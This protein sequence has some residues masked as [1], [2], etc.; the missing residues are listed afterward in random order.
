MIIQYKN[1]LAFFVVICVLIGWPCNPAASSR[2]VVIG[3]PLPLTGDLKE[4]GRIMKNSFELARQTINQA[5]G[6]N[7]NPVELRFADT[8][9]NVSQADKVVKDLVAAGSVMMVGGYAS[10]PT[11]RMA[12]RAQQ[13]NLPF[14]ISTA[15]ADKITRRGWKN[16]YRLNPP[17][18][19]YTKGLEDF[20]VKNLKPRSM[21]IVYENSM[22]GTTG[23]MRM[24]EFCQDRAI[25]IRA[26][27]TYDRTTARPAYLHSLLAPLTAEPPDVIYMIAYLEDAVMLVQQ[28]R[29]LK[30][31]A[32]L[33]GGAGGFALEEFARRAGNAANHLLTASLWSQNV[34]Y[35][36]A[37]AYYTQYT[38]RYGSLPSYH[39]AEAYAAL[40]VAVDALKRAKSFRPQDV[41]AALD[42]TYMQTPFGPV[43]F[44]HYEDFKRQNSVNTLVLQIIDGKFETVW[45]PEVASTQ[46]SLP[47]G[48]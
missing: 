20:W 19:E 16:I 31:P 29:A 6:V 40:L 37:M 9:G 43:K 12:K 7:G 30:I 44:Y 18:S 4:F 32:L 41:R 33:C 26:Q 21:A 13:K 34:P 38:E 27:I 15:S 35:P 5:G 47:G 8:G 10:D 22:F 46:F 14:L 45:P 3:A 11:Y 24:M 17:I 1:W 42:L 28:I 36:D 25:E 39:G 48:D 2:P 23:A